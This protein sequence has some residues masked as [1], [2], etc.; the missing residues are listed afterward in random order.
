MSV[1]VSK[2]PHHH[3]KPL[4]QGS[5]PMTTNVRRVSSK[6]AAPRLIPARPLLSGRQ[7]DIDAAF[8]A[9]VEKVTRKLTH[10]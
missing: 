5:F 9:G 10:H 7:A 2:T 4:V 1:R 3:D 6:E 8:E